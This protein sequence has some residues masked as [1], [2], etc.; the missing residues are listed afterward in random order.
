MDWSGLLNLYKPKDLHMSPCKVMEFLS[1]VASRQKATDNMFEPLQEVIDL[2][3]HFGMSIPN[4]SLAQLEELPEKWANTKR[5]SVT[6]KQQVLPLMGMEVGKLRSRIEE[7][8]RF[9]KNYRNVYTC[10][11]FFDY[12]CKS[13]YEGLSKAQVKID[14]FM[15]KIRTLQ[16]EAVLFEVTVPEYALIAQCRLENKMLKQMWDYIFLV[17]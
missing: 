8:D 2:L 11:K 7:Y 10:L 4:E 15:K 12:G 3:R 16:A 17:R 14:E 5:L 9:Q 1:L 13:P 6:A